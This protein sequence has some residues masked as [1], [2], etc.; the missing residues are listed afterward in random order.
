MYKFLLTKLDQ[1]VYELFAY[2]FEQAI[3]RER[4]SDLADKVNLSKRRIALVFERA[5]DLQNSYPFFEIDMH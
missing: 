5:R 4:L 1:D 3:D 2:F